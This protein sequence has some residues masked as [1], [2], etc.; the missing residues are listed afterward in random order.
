MNWI[1]SI[2]T[3]LFFAINHL[4]HVGI[5][6]SF[7][8]LLSGIGDA[9]IVW[10]VIGAYLIFREEKKDHRLFLPLGV[11][12]GFTWSITELIVKPLV[13]RLRPSS[14]LDAA[15]VVG[16]FPLGYSFP[17]THATIAFALATV[18]VYKE[19]K[20]KKGL[21]GLAFAIAL[22]R[23][24][25]GHHYPID[26]I[27]GGMFGWGIGF[28]TVSWYRWY[29]KHVLMSKQQNKTSKKRRLRTHHYRYRRL[30]K[31]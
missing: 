17:S 19:P 12:A 24:Y 15:T 6:D 8:L 26:V 23:I 29:K 5:I 20:W 1:L 27:V 22:S 16:G 21:Y 13:A 10:F 18:L 31:R 7:A 4:P 2:D 14:A 30:A 3:Q 28:F 25:L 11:S 9:G